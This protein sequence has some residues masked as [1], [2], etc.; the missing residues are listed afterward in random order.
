MTMTH[1]ER[2]ETA[3]RLEEPDRV[4]IELELSAHAREHP[5]AGR[6][7]E[8]IEEHADNF[9]WAP[10]AGWGFFGF[11]TQYREEVFEDRPGV[12]RRMRRVHETP[13]G[14][15]TA[16]TFHPARQLDYHWEKRF[17]A[18]PDDLRRLA[19]TPRP[20]LTWD[21]GAW[22]ARVR[23]AG[24]S[25]LPLVSVMHP[26]GGLVRSAT[27]EAM[28]AWFYEERALVHRFLEAANRQVAETVAGMVADGIGPCF[29]V[30]AHE[31][32]LPP[33]MGHKLFDEFVFP[34]DK[35]VNDIIRRSGGKLRAHIH[36]NCMDFLEK[37]WEMG[38]DAVEPLESPPV[39]DVNLAEAKRR[40]GGRMML[41]GNVP[42]P[43]FITL[44]PREVRR[45]V[46]DA[47]R[48]AAPG[49]GFSLRTTGGA[50]GTSV[51]M[52]DDE[53]DR[54]LQNCEAYM[55]AGLQYGRYPIKLR[56]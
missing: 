53:M 34:Y 21:K 43:L 15:F 7:V 38:I 20:P 40:I 47:I 27:M 19:E 39:G 25:A 41:S 49:G 32:L 13:A 50:G 33:W 52:S 1:R 42:S 51:Q 14:T 29:S 26:L 16:V 45:M 10:G 55:L 28:Y 2:L 35:A 3:W 24:E 44:T 31:M 17:I 5:R 4:P 36:G 54:A 23:E 30:C 48:V 11:P 6:V 37:L 12:G 8:L 46:K 9:T 18:S 56:Q 22:S